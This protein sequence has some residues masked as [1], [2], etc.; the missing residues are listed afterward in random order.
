MCGQ[1]DLYTE[2]IKVGYGAAMCRNPTS[3]RP[4][5]PL[6]PEQQR[7]VATSNGDILFPQRFAQLECMLGASSQGPYFA[8]AQ[9][10]IADLSFYVLASA[11]LAGAWVGNGVGADA[12]DGCERLLKIEKLV[13]EHPRVA[14]WNA[15]HPRSWFG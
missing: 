7:A 5:V 3:G 9:L 2:L 1:D 4:M 14:S 11:I 6:T 15:E 8:G 10:T 13:S 12:L